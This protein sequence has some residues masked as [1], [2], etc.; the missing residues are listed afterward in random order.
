MRA[1]Q[2]DST[3]GPRGERGEY[4]ARILD[5]ARIEFG[6]HGWSGTTI[7]GIARAADVDPALVYHYF[8]SKRNLLGA[9]IELPHEWLEGIRAGWNAPADQLG[10]VMVR[11]TMR[12]WAEPR[13]R[14]ILR[15]IAL[16]AA[17]EPASKDRL[18]S[19]VRGILM[20]PADP[21]VDDAER[22]RRSALAASQLLGFVMMKYVWQI[23]PVASMDEG[24]AVV[25][26]APTVQRYLD[27]SGGAR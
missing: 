19:L 18:Q 12:N 6:T 24:E 8:G 13:F 9:A 21:G 2:K 17:I 26:L 20:R 3:P 27:G 14:P 16:T 7:R 23:E 10:E 25:F 15:A 11:L 4:S 5:A 22:I 1:R